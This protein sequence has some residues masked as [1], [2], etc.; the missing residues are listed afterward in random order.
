MAMLFYFFKHRYRESDWDDDAEGGENPDPVLSMD[1]E[2][3]E[4]ACSLQGWPRKK[5]SASSW[6]NWEPCFESFCVSVPCCCWC[7]RRR[8]RQ[9]RRRL[10]RHRSHVSASPRGLTDDGRSEAMTGEHRFRC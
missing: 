10:S 2:N 9:R 4:A 1:C 3:G 5:E 7:R 8:R 6:K